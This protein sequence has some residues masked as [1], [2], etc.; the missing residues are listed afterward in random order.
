[1]IK[2][3]ED[4]SIQSVFLY[5]GTIMLNLSESQLKELAASHPVVIEKFEIAEA[6][7]YGIGWFYLIVHTKTHTKPLI[8]TSARKSARR[9]GNVNNLIRMIRQLN[10][11]SAHICVTLTEDAGTGEPVRPKSRT[12]RKS[13]SIKPSST[14]IKK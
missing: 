1:M 12:P 2:Q 5:R 9:W 14:R 8:L 11:K 4:N 10:V 3:S 6:A 7:D 13:G